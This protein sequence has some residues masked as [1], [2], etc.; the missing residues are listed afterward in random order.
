MSRKKLLVT[1]VSG[2]IAGALARTLVRSHE[3]WGLARFGDAAKREALEEAGVVT[4]SVDL[5]DPD[6]SE[7]PDDFD[8][9]L[10]LSVHQGPGT[11]WNYAVEVNAV[12]TGL[13][14]AH[15][16]GV[17]SA[18]VMSTTG[19][20][21]PHPDPWHNYV[22]TDPLGDPTSPSTPTYG[23]SKVSQE[24]VTR[25]CAR[26]FGL[27]VVIGR[28][29]ASYGPGGGLPA[30][31]IDRLIAGEPIVLRHDPAP[32]S[33]IY[34]DDIADHAIALLDAA[35]VPATIVNFGGDEVVTAQQWIAYAADLLGVTP[36]IQVVPIPGSQPGIALD[37]SKRLA[38]TG[39]D[40]V[41]WQEGVRRT[42]EARRAAACSTP[43]QHR[44]A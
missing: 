8:H 21:R 39:P 25:F 1:G 42:V 3:V 23:V 43:G 30:K 18:L 44:T 41:P 20:Y 33:P 27:P 22:E 36:T 32:Y 11:D 9:V 4:R 12:G 13:L 16:R 2:Q 6:F 31:H 37:V 17:R 34:E 19:V 35:A 29:N 10:H 7:L 28:M 38:L 40:K 14:L 5:A 15:F 26:Q 24:A